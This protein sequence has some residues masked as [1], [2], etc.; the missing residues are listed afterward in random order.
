MAKSARAEDAGFW[1]D[2]APAG[3]EERKA[4]DEAC[5]LYWDATMYQA[6]QPGFSPPPEKAKLATK[7]RRRYKKGA[8]LRD[9]RMGLARP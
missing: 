7:A 2:Q 6:A 3:S 1:R 5:Q 8:A 4:F 9:K